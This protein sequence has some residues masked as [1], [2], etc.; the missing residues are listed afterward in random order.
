MGYI[1]VSLKERVCVQVII[2]VVVILCTRS[3]VDRL[4]LLAV[5]ISSL[6]VV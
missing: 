4:C 5:P 2:E 3:G 1:V 6:L